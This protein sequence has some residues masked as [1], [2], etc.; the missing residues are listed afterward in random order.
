MI[1]N[2]KFAKNFIW[3][4]IGSTLASFSSVF[5]LIIITRI[6]GIEEAGI[7]TITFATASIFYIVA[8]YSGRNCQI[9]D[10]EGKIKDK[11]YI[12]SRVITCFIMAII[13]F[14]YVLIK[15]YDTHKSAILIFL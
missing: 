1:K 13:V 14:F 15:N 4:T 6:N 11:E 9:T 2:K 10:V 8:I 12:I 7:F 3:N 5:L